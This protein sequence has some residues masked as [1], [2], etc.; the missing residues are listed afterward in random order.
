MP[1]SFEGISHNHGGL[2]PQL[3]RTG[4]VL[5]QDPF[6]L[7]KEGNQQ[8]GYIILFFFKEGSLL[9]GRNR[10]GVGLRVGVGVA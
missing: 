6:G 5:P 1:G 10:I 8:N 4:A 3:A 2:H 7:N 9:L